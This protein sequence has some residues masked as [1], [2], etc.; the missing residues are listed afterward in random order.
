MPSFTPFRGVKGSPPPPRHELKYFIN[1]GDYVVLSR[2][3]NQVLRRDVHGDADNNYFIRSLY[4]DDAYNS[5]FMDKVTGV[6]H[7]DKY[8]IRIYNLSDREIFLERKRKIGDLI[9]KSSARI[10]KRLCAQLIE[11]NPQGL[12]ASENPL[13]QDVFREM[14]LRLLKPVVIV[15][16]LREAY[17][18][19]AENVRITF[20]KELR[21]GLFSRDLFS[22]ELPTL[23]PLDDQSLILEVKYDRYL[24]DYLAVLLSQ[25]PAN[26][27]AISKYVLCR[28]FEPLG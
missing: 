10:T 20:D 26:R 28:R 22:Q 23:S 4:F 6:E 18:H 16:Y 24:P 8:R 15:D 25:V 3:L 9:Q 5:A 19:P 21:T 14:R 17:W 1:R 13:I 27:S 2:L 11:G 7:R 12:D